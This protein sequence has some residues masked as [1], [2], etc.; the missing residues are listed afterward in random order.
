MGGQVGSASACY[1]CSL[2]S[3]PDIT[4]KCKI[5]D[6]SKEV[7]NALQPAQKNLQKNY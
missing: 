2:D 6:I 1:D 3:N 7:A 4:Q 5:G